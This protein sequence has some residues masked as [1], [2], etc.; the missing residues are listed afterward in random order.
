MAI[1][2]GAVPDEAI[3]EARE[4]SGFHQAE[5]VEKPFAD[6]EEVEDLYG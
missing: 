6:T 1:V 2:D 5:F 4:M 3:E